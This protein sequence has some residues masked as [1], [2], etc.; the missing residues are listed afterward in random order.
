ML[1][2]AKAE[3]GGAECV[4]VS[5]LVPPCITDVNQKLWQFMTRFAEAEPPFGDIVNTAQYDDVVGEALAGAVA[6]ACANLPVG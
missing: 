3:C 4:F 6:E 1:L 5:G 2:D